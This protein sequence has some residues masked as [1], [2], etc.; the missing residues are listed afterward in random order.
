[1]MS[2]EKQESVAGPFAAS[3]PGCSLTKASRPYSITPTREERV[4]ARL[5]FGVIVVP[6]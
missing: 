6:T 2:L 5:S 3:G 4:L 1:M